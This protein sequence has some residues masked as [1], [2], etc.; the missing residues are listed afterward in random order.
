MNAFR[1]YF[2]LLSYFLFTLATG[3]AS[4]SD[5][6]SFFWQEANSMMASAREPADFLQAAATYQKLVDTGARNGPVFANLGAALLQANRNQDALNAFLR[7]ERYLGYD[8]EITRGIQ[9]AIARI[10]KTPDAPL[11]WYRFLLS[12]HFRLA[13]ATRAWIAGGA[14]CLFWVALTF[15]RVGW[16]RLARPL[17]V[18]ALVALALFGSSAAT[19]LYQEANATR[20]LLLLSEGGI[21]R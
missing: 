5:E 16:H 11:P 17:L 14:F 6:R 10:E 3:F 15:R 20:P 4:N 12:W 7:A 21:I 13:C 19:S 8:R 1:S 2:I 9:T 18:L